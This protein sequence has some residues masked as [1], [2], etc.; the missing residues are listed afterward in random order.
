MGFYTPDPRDYTEMK[1]DK[2]KDQFTTLSSSLYKQ[3][4]Y[5]NTTDLVFLETNSGLIQMMDRTGKPMTKN[6]YLTYSYSKKLAKQQKEKKAAILAKKR[7]AY[8]IVNCFDRRERRYFAV[9]L[10][11]D[12]Y[13]E[14]VKDIHSIYSVKITGAKG[15]LKKSYSLVVSCRNDHV[16]ELIGKFEFFSNF[17]SDYGVKYTEI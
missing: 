13:D 2:I 6:S 11:Y 5:D 3:V 16:K 9:K 7:E 12:V 17:T 14:A 8:D 1:N 10:S 15:K 4:F